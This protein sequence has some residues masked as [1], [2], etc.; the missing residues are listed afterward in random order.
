MKARKKE[1]SDTYIICDSCESENN[2]MQH[3]VRLVATN[4][5]RQNCIVEIA[6]QSLIKL[7]HSVQSAVKK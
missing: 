5:K 3:F 6:E 2:Q 4:S 7:I 1:I